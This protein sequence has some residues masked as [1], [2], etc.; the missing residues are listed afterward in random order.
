MWNHFIVWVLTNAT[1]F[2]VSYY[3]MSKSTDLLVEHKTDLYGT[4]KC[5]EMKCLMNDKKNCH[6]SLR[7][8]G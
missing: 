3:K 7:E 4:P 8:R 5:L 1:F 6:Q 2:T